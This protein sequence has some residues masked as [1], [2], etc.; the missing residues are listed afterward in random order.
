MSVQKLPSN[1]ELEWLRQAWKNEPARAKGAL[2]PNCLVERA[3]GFIA[4]HSSWCSVGRRFEERLK[5]V[6]NENKIVDISELQRLE[7]AAWKKRVQVMEYAETERA[8]ISTMVRYADN[9]WNDAY[10][11]LR[12]AQKQT[13]RI[14]DNG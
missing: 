4:D 13:A 5:L 14:N 3:G 12:E 9:E 10:Q 2:C 7:Q 8:K 6:A 11:H 1:E